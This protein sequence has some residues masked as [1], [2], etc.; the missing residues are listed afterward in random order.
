[1]RVPI[2]SEERDILTA[3]EENG[4]LVRDDLDER[5]AEIARQMVTRGLLLRLRV[6]GNICFGPNADHNLR[7]F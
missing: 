3:V 4:H 2:S 1:M 5:K 7:R 6:D